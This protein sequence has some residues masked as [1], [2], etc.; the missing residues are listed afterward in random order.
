MKMHILLLTTFAVSLCG[1]AS[2]S[3]SPEEAR[4]F[5]RDFVYPYG[6]EGSWWRGGDFTRYVLTHMSEFWFHTLLTKGQHTVELPNAIRN[7]VAGFQ[8]QTEGFGGTLEDYV[9]NSP[10]DGAIVIQSGRIVFE[11][12]PRMKMSDKHSWFSVS[13]V[14]VS[15]AIGILEKEGRIEVSRPASDYLEMLQGTEWEG[16]P[17]LDILDMAS[18]MDVNVAYTDQA[19]HFYKFY[20]ALGWPSFDQAWPNPKE[21]LGQIGKLRPAGEVQEYSGVN[22]TALSWIIE[23]IS[24]QRYPDFITEKIWKRMGAGSDGLML[25]SPKGDSVSDTGV[26]STLRDLARLGL[27]YTPAGRKNRIAAVSDAHLR[28][29]QEEGRPELLRNGNPDNYMGFSEKEVSHNTYQWDIVFQDGD[30][31]K[32]GFNGQGLYISPKKDLV[33]AFFGTKEFK[34]PPNRMRQIARQLAT[35]GIFD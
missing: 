8:V 18:G 25:I 10:T 5:H 29:I 32:D 19:T 33:I 14:L 20:Q 13:K 15:L 6:K 24:N 2:S 28:K 23:S 11:A 34:G 26:S 21:Y 31:Y 9:N 4:E 12:Y 16:I 7:D 27:L 1:Q 35:S 3:P 22:T 30:F 17:V